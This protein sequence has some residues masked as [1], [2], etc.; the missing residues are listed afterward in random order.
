[1]VQMKI[2]LT[3]V[4]ENKLLMSVQA[5]FLNVQKTFDRSRSSLGLHGNDFKAGSKSC[6]L[7]KQDSYITTRVGIT[8]PPSYS[9]AEDNSHKVVR[10]G[11][12]PMIQ[13][14][15]GRSTPRKSNVVENEKKCMDKGSKER[16]PPHNLRQ[17]PGQYIC[18][19]NHKLIADIEN[20]IMDSSDA[21]HNPSQPFG[22]LSTET[23]G[24]LLSLRVLKLNALIG[25]HPSDTNVF[26]MKMEICL[27]NII[28]VLVVTWRFLMNSKLVTTGYQFGPVNELTVDEF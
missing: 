10:L 15:T 27:P 25:E 5:P 18:C 20:D 13:P 4:K 26:T 3:N 2:S 21:M 12:H 24:N 16:S 19:Q 17:K 28:Q 22:F 6:S 11:N 23:C 8:I 7:S 1:M 9:N 14:G